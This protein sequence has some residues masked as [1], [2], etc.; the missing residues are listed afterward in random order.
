MLA[1]REEE[2]REE[3]TPYEG[4]A[5]DEEFDASDP[6]FDD[7]ELEL[8]NPWKNQLPTEVFLVPVVFAVNAL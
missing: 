5:P 8:L 7:E 6:V 2:E 4:G 1:R 3:T